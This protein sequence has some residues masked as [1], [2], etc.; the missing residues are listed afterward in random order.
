[1]PVPSF[2]LPFGGIGIAGG[3]SMAGYRVMDTTGTNITSPTNNRGF[4][5]DFAAASRVLLASKLGLPVST[6][7]AAV[8]GCSG[9]RPIRRY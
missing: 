5:V 6:T 1:M 4:S 7:H 3:I 2:L 9:S 8:G